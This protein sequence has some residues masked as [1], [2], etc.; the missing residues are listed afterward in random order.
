MFNIILKFHLDLI[1][2]SKFILSDYI[3]AA[4]KRAVYEKLDDGSYSGVIPEC[5]GVIAFGSSLKDC[6]YQLRS[7]LED[8]ILLGLKLGHSIPVIDKID[9]NKKVENI[10]SINSV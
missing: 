8:W 7:V 9:L 5:K 2:E 3:E 1:M 10:E 4:L 6:E